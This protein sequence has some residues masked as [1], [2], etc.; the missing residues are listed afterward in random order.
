MCGLGSIGRR[1][2]RIF[3]ELGV[4]RIDVF[5][6]GKAT[7]ADGDDRPPDRA[8]RNLDEALGEHPQAVVVSNPTSL[9]VECALKALHAGCHVLVEKPIAHSVGAARELA[10]AARDS[11]RVVA[12]A[13][14]LRHHPSLQAVRRAIALGVLG[15][16]LVA[17]FHFGTFLPK[18]HPWEDYRIS[19][20]A[21]RDLGGGA[22]RTHVHEIDAA[23][24]L[25][26]SATRAIGMPLSLHPLGTDVD[27]AS[28]FILSHDSGCLSSITLSLAQDPPART[29]EV[30]FERGTITLD[31]LTTTRVTRFAS[32]E[33][34]TEGSGQPMIWDDTYRAQ[35]RAF[36]SAVDE[37]RPGADLVGVRE[38]CMAL[39]ISTLIDAPNDPNAF[40]I[41]KHHV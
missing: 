11:G 15:L 39:E 4:E 22:A 5:R 1:H 3:R 21:K 16:P 2:L 28:A 25:F 34:A 12:V 23:L 18:W 38:A 29:L 24:W 30:S 40:S 7:L 17:R 36:L 10:A 33:A 35:A 9:H 26:G 31:L 19:Y 32:G 27:E 14:N 8:F 37:G 20:A 13:H 6:S 41:W